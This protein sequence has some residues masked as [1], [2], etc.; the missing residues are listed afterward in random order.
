MFESNRVVP[1]LI[2]SLLTAGLA[3]AQ[4]RQ[5]QPQRFPPPRA[6]NIVVPQSRAFGLGAQPVVEIVRVKASISILDGVAST[7]LEVFLVNP[8]P[9]ILEAELLVPVPSKAVVR[10]FAFEGPAPEPTA[11]LLPLAEATSTYEAIVARSRDPAL[12]EFVGTNV[13]RSSVFPVPANGRQRV[14]LTYDHVLPSDGSRVE[15]ILP[16]TESLDYAVPWDIGVSIE[17]SQPVSTAYSPS[18]EIELTRNNPG[19]VKVE[20]SHGEGE[21]P[22]AFHLCYL[23]DAPG[24]SSTLFAYPDPQAGGGYFLLLCAPPADHGDATTPRIP[25]EVTIVIDRSGSMRGGKL[26]QAS[27]AA[28]EVLGSL[29]G[30]ERFRL[31]SYNEAVETHSTRPV[32]ALPGNLA[33]ARQWLQQL[34]PSGGTNIYDALS[35]AIR[36]PVTPNALP[37][38]LFL[39]DG[40]PTIG[41]TEEAAILEL[42]RTGNRA[43]RRLFTFGVGFDV[44]TPLLETLASDSRAFATFVLPGEDL[45]FKVRQVYRALEGPVLAEPRLATGGRARD[46]VPD[47][48]PDLFAGQQLVVAGRYVGSRP[49]DFELSGNYRGRSRTFRM[50]FTLDRATTSNAFVPRIWASRRIGVL[51]DAIRRRGAEENVSPVDSQFDELVNEIVRLSTEFGVLTEYTAFLALEGTRLDEVEEVR[52]EAMRNLQGRAV[53]SRSGAAAVNQELNI[54]FKKRQKTLNPKNS[55]IT[56]DLQQAEVNTVQQIGDRAFF[57]RGGRWVDSRLVQRQS[58]A[59]TREIAFNSPEFHRLLA[60]LVAANRQGSLAL[61]GDVLLEVDGKPVLVKGP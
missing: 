6:A 57:N 11:E 32:R 24:V 53:Q 31:I 50:R 16:R 30:D 2:A 27:R 8:V 40:L 49:L 21:K 17:S 46:L 5:R 29:E 33:A 34:R 22:G 9:R 61:R 7:I 43:G 18:H 45:E 55:Y 59:Q 42:A 14:R 15:Y 37:I 28:W 19:R 26:D 35:E 52:A 44:N 48:L 58:Q 10:G 12:L 25:R 39:T 56:K 47:E 4:I 51:V 1:I 20:L 23:R 38:V 60:R 54:A 3:S 41:R 13:V 36:Q